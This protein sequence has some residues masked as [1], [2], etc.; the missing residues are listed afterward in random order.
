MNNA[1]VCG[2]KGNTGGSL[3]VNMVKQGIISL[4][5]RKVK[6]RLANQTC[7]SCSTV[8]HQQWESRRREW[9]REV[10]SMIRWFDGKE[11]RLLCI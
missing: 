4:P 2:A 9:D 7:A 5:R 11:L 1:L 10:Q 8:Y 6:Y 3:D